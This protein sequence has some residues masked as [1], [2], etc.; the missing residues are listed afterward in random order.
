MR[1]FIVGQKYSRDTIHD[2]LGSEIASYLPTPGHPIRI[3]HED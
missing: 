1:D 3:I 2:L